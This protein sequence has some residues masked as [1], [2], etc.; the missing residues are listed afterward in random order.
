M[1]K[2]KAWTD[3]PFVELGDKPNEPAPIRECWVVSYDG[4]KYCII[5]ISHCVVPFLVVKAGY[6]YDSPGRSGEVPVIQI[7][8]LIQG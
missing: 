1:N 4:D 7:D 5:S 3:Y 8:K 2:M 6:L